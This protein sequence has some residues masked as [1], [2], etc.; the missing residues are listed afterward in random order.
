MGMSLCGHSGCK[1]KAEAQRPPPATAVAPTPPPAAAD[2]PPGGGGNRRT[3]YRRSGTWVCG[4]GP[5]ENGTGLEPQR[6]LL[7]DGC[8]TGGAAGGE[9]AVGRRRRR[10]QSSLCLT[11]ACLH[12]LLRY[13]TCFCGRHTASPTLGSPGRGAVE[14]CRARGRSVIASS[15]LGRW[16]G[17]LK[18][19]WGAGRSG[20]GL[21]PSRPG[22]CNERTAHW[23]VE[24][25]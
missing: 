20:G 12:A 21:M 13:A 5:A 23:G 10:W 22:Q 18:A 11:P 1:V 17:L 3:G 15:L 2:R 7:P 25:P 9:R 8:V 14:L 16:H 24:R 4:A 19:V 6:G